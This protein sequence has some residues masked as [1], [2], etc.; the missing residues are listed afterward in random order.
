MILGNKLDEM[1]GD[2]TGSIEAS[3]QSLVASQRASTMILGG[4]LDEM[5]NDI[6]GSIEASTQSLVA[7]QRVSTMILGGKLDNL[8]D[9]MKAGF[10]G[11]AGGIFEVSRQIGEMGSNINMRLVRLDDTVQKSA[12]ALCNKLDR[13]SDILNN[14]SLTQSR[15]YY[16]RALTNYTKGFYE[17]ALEEV[18]ECTRINRVD[19][20]AWFLTGK[21]YLFGQGDFSNVVDL[22][23]AIQAFTQ[24]VKYITPDSKAIPEARLL[25]S[26]IFFHQALAK[27]NKVYD[28]LHNGNKEGTEQLLSE[29]A[30]AFEQS[31]NLSPKM[32]EALYNAARCYTGLGNIGEA[33]KCLEVLIREEPSYALKVELDPDFNPQQTNTGDNNG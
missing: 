7:S 23:A 22:N 6:T 16:A 19:Y 2:I 28:D 27:Q 29:A 15:E 10:T 9:T 26:E 11:L 3:T 31:Y 24:A 1:T 14:P 18:R 21:I 8:N 13:I 17:E 32:L 33:I 4:K 12:N 30:Q 25:A 5:A 20:I